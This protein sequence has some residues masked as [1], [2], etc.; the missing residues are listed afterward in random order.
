VTLTSPVT[1]SGQLGGEELMKSIRGQLIKLDLDQRGTLPHMWVGLVIG[2]GLGV[3][4]SPLL[5][6]VTPVG[7]LC[8]SLT[9]LLAVACSGGIPAPLRGLANFYGAAASTSVLTS[10]HTI[11]AIGH[12][13]GVQR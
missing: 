6:A 2:S 10:D 13:F 7:V 12:L 3:L 9:G 4:S 11:R 5:S 8:L 1:D